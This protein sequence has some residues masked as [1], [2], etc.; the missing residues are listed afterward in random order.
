MSRYKLPVVLF[1]CLLAA[2]SGDSS[3]LDAGPSAS[4][5]ATD[6]ADSGESEMD[7]G[8]LDTGVNADAAPRDAGS[9][10]PS[11]EPFRTLRDR[12]TPASRIDIVIVGDGYTADELATTYAAHASNLVDGMFQR[13]SNRRDVTQPFRQYGNLFNV[14]RVHLA[15]NESGIDE[16]GTERDT[17][18]DGTS[19]CGGG[20]G[21]GLCYVDK[22]KVHAAID[23]ALAGSGITPDWRIVVLNTAEKAAG[24]VE[25]PRGN[26]AV[27]PGGFGGNA[28]QLARMLGLREMAKAFAGVE[29]EFGG[30]TTPY[31]GP[32]FSAPNVTVTATAPKWA[33]WM[34]YD[35]NQDDISAIGS[36]EGGAGYDRG[37]YRPTE[38]S[39]MGPIN[40]G[41]TYRYN[42][43][44]REA[45][46]LAMYR[47]VSLVLDKEDNSQTLVDPI[48]LWVQTL[49]QDLLDV[50]WSIGDRI[51]TDQT[52]A[53]LG[54]TDW[55]AR[56]G[57]TAGTYT[58]TARVYD[59]TNWVRIEPRSGLEESVSWTVELTR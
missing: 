28:T 15:S 35:D 10:D 23:A 36:Y 41:N 19:S 39:K 21:G 42:A 55:A 2:C 24:V 26:I 34:G 18:L 52:D 31:T 5:D 1:T 9:I 56:N 45:I 59:N 51:I 50:E 57:I 47:M 32:E 8:L 4:L 27:Y 30:I 46:I 43:V 11:A 14:H 44:T 40:T 13:K 53:A 6:G 58:V 33:H 37:V 3:G 22:D 7:A 17:A 48:V 25:D 38:V 49:D 29:Y 16:G 20:F 54:I 12:G